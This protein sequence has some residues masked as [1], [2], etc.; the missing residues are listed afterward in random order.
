MGA[1]GDTCQASCNFLLHGKEKCRE[2]HYISQELD[3]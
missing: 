1:E 3:F 2:R